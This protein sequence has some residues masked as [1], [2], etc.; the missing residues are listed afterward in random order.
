MRGEFSTAITRQVSRGEGAKEVGVEFTTM[1][2]SYT[3]PAGV[4]ASVLAMRD[5]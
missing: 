4:S 1:S 5:D 2:K 3:W